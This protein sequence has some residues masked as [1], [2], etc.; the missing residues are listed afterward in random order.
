MGT[1]FGENRFFIIGLQMKKA[2]FRG[3]HKATN[4]KGS[5]RPPIAM[6]E[7]RKSPVSLMK[8]GTVSAGSAMI[9]ISLLE[10]R[11]EAHHY[12]P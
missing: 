6:S 10:R 8:P 12:Q 3:A 9:G 4:K 11:N 2:V 1:S 5:A 7:G